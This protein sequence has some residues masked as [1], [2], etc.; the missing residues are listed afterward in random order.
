MIILQR[1]IEKENIYLKISDDNFTINNIFSTSLLSLSQW[2]SLKVQI[3]K[4]FKVAVQIN[5]NENLESIKD[6]LSFFSMI[7]INFITFKDGRPFSLVKE[8]RKKYN[9]NEEIRASGHIL[10]DQY[11]FLLRCGFSTVE[12]KKEEKAVWIE[13]LEI[14]DGLYYQP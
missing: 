3:K 2:Q 7:Q 6:D 5:S 8:L 12:I 11:V 4:K 10:P 1:K 13:L 14:D 9:F